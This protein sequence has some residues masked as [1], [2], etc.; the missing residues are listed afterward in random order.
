MN[1]RATI[2]TPIG[3]TNPTAV[4]QARDAGRLYEAGSHAGSLPP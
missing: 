4:R 3:M 1:P 2:A